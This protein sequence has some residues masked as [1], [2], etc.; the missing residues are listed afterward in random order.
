MPASFGHVKYG[1]QMIEEFVTGD[2]LGAEGHHVGGGLLTVHEMK[3]P[4]LQLSHERDQR[5]F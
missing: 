5:D 1:G 2:I 3:S 4:G